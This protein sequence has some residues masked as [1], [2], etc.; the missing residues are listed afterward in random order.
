MG[1]G[2]S[3]EGAGESDPSAGVTEPPAFLICPITQ[4]VM[5]DP[6]VVD[7]GFTFEREAIEDWFVNNNTNPMT[8]EVLS[9]TTVSPNFAIREACAAFRA[10]RPD[11]AASIAR[12]EKAALAAAT[13]AKTTTMATTKEKRTVQVAASSLHASNEDSRQTA[14]MP[15]PT[16]LSS[17][18]SEHTVS[19]PSGGLHSPPSWVT[20]TASAHSSSGAISGTNSS[21]PPSWVTGSSAGR[22]KSS[23]A[24]VSSPPSWATASA[25]TASSPPSLRVSPARND[26]RSSSSSSADAKRCGLCGDFAVRRTKVGDDWIAVC[27]GCSNVIRQQQE[28]EVRKKFGS[29][30]RRSTFTALSAA[31]AAQHALDSVDKLGAAGL[32]VE[33]SPLPQRQTSSVS[34]TSPPRPRARAVSVA[35]TRAGSAAPSDLHAGARSVSGNLQHL[36]RAEWRSASSDNADAIASRIN[37]MYSSQ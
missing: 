28:M 12:Y 4:E 25:V 18:L 21:S 17:P 2:A 15:S 6:V 3:A 20:S 22:Q 30:Q 1:A 32:R 35:S 5:H 7:G 14:G 27:N 34:R 16:R 31:D 9:N 8:G 33:S 24:A 23:S 29:V 13:K 10:Q 26:S 37:R 36:E 19:S 11:N